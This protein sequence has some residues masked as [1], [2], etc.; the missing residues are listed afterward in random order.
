MKRNIGFVFLAITAATLLLLASCRHDPSPAATGWSYSLVQ[1]Q[2]ADS[3]YVYTYTYD[4]TGRQI[5]AQTDTMV[6][7]Y[8]YSAG[9]VVKTLSLAGSLFIT[10]YTTDASGHAVS[11]SKGYTYTYDT[12][13][14]LTARYYTSAGS[15]DSVT[16]TVSGGNVDTTV[17]HQGDALTSSLITTTYTYL[18]TKDSRNFGLSYLG[19]PNV[20]LIATQNISQVLNGTSYTAYYIYSYQYDSKGRV[21][22]QNIYNG[23]A[24]YN[25]TYKYF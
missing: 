14:Y 18:T 7:T 2:I 16:Y 9:S 22:T 24:N 20:N 15:Y 3:G 5:R 12:N 11:D 13:G 19:T 23:S 17:E 6:T 10:D 4:T 21:S 25:T 8:G 1:S